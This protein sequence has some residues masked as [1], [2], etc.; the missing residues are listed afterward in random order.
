MT[1]TDHSPLSD[2]PL[3]SSSSSSAF[4]FTILNDTMDPMEAM[5][6]ASNVDT[7]HDPAF[8]MTSADCRKPESHFRNQLPIFD[9]DSSSRDHEEHENTFGESFDSLI[10]LLQKDQEDSSQPL[11]RSARL[12][13]YHNRQPSATGYDSGHSSRQHDT[14][15]GR[16]DP[17]QGSQSLC[18]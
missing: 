7:Y 14:S 2:S 15:Y 3:M 10:S 13:T 11:K 17:I 4:E 1:S 5:K 18:T 6:N 9:Y 12:M 16:F 8:A